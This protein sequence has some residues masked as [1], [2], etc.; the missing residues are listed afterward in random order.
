MDDL[1]YSI[2]I[3]R[4]LQQTPQHTN[5]HAPRQHHSFLLTHDIGSLNQP[6]KLH[7]HP[8]A[9]ELNTAKMAAIPVKV[10]HQG[11]TYDIEIDP[12]STG[13][14]LQMQLYS[15]TNV[16]PENQ[17]IMAGKMIKADTQLSTIKFKP[18]QVI[19][20]LGKPSAE[21]VMA[22]P[23]EKTKFLEDMTDA[24][25]A[26][27]DGA[28]PAGLNNTGNTCYANATLQTLRMIPELQEQLQ[29]YK[30]SAPAGT[31][32]SSLFSA[33]QL[34]NVGLGGLGGANDL[35]GSLRDV[36]KMMGETQGAVQPLMFLTALRQQYPQF[37]EKSKTGGHY[38]QQ[39]AE[40]MWSQLISTL[41]Q[42]LK[43]DKKDGSDEGFNTWVEK[44]MG[45]RFETVTKSDEA[46]DEEPIIGTDGFRDLKCNISGDTNHLREGLSIGLNEQFEKRSE[47]LGR[48]AVYK[49]TSRIARLPKYLPIHFMRFLW[50]RDT[51]KKAKI[52]RKVSFQHEIDL[53]E[54]CT[55]ELRA[56][57]VPVRDRVRE[58][59]KEI[60]DVERQ[61]KR[62]KRRRQDI[63]DEA[64]GSSKIAKD[65]PF[66][67]RAQ[68]EKERETKATGPASEGD[69]AAEKKGGDTAMGGTEEVFKTDAE[70]EQERAESIRNAKKDLLAAV[71]PDMAKD[72]SAN[73]T[74][75]YE[76][77]G[78]VTHQGSSADS[79][80]YTAYVKKTALPGQEEDGK[81]WWF[82][83]D[84]VSE[85]DSEK[86]ETLSGGG[87][88][89]SALILLYR[90]VELPKIE[91]TQ[92]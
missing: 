13:E 26:K 18:N 58:V 55:D 82:N 81:W 92:E 89:H 16:E 91:E 11:K 5:T 67:K 69:L 79:G 54:Y 14:E 24:E 36:Y 28:M 15:L 34:A 74:G 2:G 17:K 80:H 84:K 76:L 32:S 37:A 35:T 60:E 88:S 50:R 51:G 78:L 48:D 10:K 65:E 31:A 62:Q 33:D 27:Q 42:S 4:L 83:D 21:V 64:T 72:S 3:F 66:Q 53:L 56:K 52:L 49:K 25:I 59:R 7:N 6:Y 46:P 85:V 8:Y 61:K 23:K 90:A 87:E 86:I 73:Q 44:Y 12:S 68:K 41:D 63:E 75:L 57:L 43:I 70:I 77:R 30:P 22:A 19:T 20:M 39:D 47:T 45:G 9:Y 71:H 38:A 29:A 40:E 1:N